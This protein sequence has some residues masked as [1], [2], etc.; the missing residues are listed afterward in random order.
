MVN[1]AKL[2]ALLAAQDWSAAEKLLRRAAKEKAPGADVFY[3]LAKVLE[4][5]GKPA[6]MHTWLKRAV[7]IKPDYAIAWFELG[8]SA[9][10]DANFEAAKIAFSKV[11]QLDPAD[12]DARIN[13]AKTALRLGAWETVLKAIS[14]LDTDEVQLLRLRARAELGEDVSDVLEGLLARPAMRPATLKA[15]TRTAKGHIPLRLP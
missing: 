13:L 5:A 14:D 15:M 10:R 8:R 1:Q 11:V 2:G 4:A 12:S 7:A 9:L 6:Q 3:N